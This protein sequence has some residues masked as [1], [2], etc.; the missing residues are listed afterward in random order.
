MLN[1][2]VVERI[3]KERIF[4]EKKIM[5]ISFISILV[6]VVA[7]KNKERSF[8]TRSFFIFSSLGFVKQD[9]CEK[10]EREKF[11]SYIIYCGIATIKS[12]IHTNDFC[13]YI[14]R[15]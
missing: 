7:K 11:L 8:F 15:S 9:I 1:V 4:Y 10:R 5:K 13:F 6:V 12:N 14:S 3:K 2:V